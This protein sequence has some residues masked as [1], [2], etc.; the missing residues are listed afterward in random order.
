MRREQF[1]LSVPNNIE[2]DWIW[3]RISPVEN[4][5]PSISFEFNFL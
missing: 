1:S 5:Q 4:A 2:L 3:K